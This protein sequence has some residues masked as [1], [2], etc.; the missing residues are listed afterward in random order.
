M[1]WDKP[2]HVAYLREAT[3]Y[4][5][6]GEFEESI[7]VLNEY[8]KINNLV[9]YYLNLSKEEIE[10]F[11]SFDEEIIEL[12]IRT[13]QAIYNNADEHISPISDETF[14]KLYE[15]YREVAGIEIVGSVADTRNRKTSAHKYPE[16]R[17][18]LDKTHF[19]SNSEKKENEKRKSV[20]DWVKSIETKLGRVL[21]SDEMQVLL[22]PKWDGISAVFEQDETH[23]VQKVLKRG[24][25]IKNEAEEITELFKGL[26]LMDYDHIHEPFGLKTEIVMSRENYKK[27]CSAFGEFKSPRSAVS[28]IINSKNPDK[29]MGK[30][31]TIVP[32]R[33][34]YSTTSEIIIP[35]SLFDYPYLTV[36]SIKDIPALEE[37]IRDLTEDVKI[38]YGI[39]ID[40]IVI[41]LLNKSVQAELG[42]E[43]NINKFEVAYKLPPEQERTIIKDVLFSV[44]VLGSVTPVAKVQPVK[45]KGNT[46]SSISLGSIERFK[47]LQLAP[48]DEVILKYDVIPYLEVDESCKRSGEPLFEIP[49]D[50]PYCGQKLEASPELKCVNDD[51]ESRVIGKIMNYVEKMSIPEISIGTITTFWK[52]GFLKTIADLYRLKEH[53]DLIINMDR[54]GH[55]S[56]QNIISGIDSRREVFDYDMVGSIG[57]PSIGRRIFKKILELYTL[58]ELMKI[59]EKNDVAKLT[60]IAGIKDKTA[61]KIIEG[62]IKNKDLIEFLKTELTIIRDTRKYTVK[63]AFTK[64]RDKEFEEYLDSRDVLVLDKYKKDVDMLIVPDY[65]TSSSKVDKARKD[66]KEILSIEDAYKLFK[67]KE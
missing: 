41:T 20:Q 18:T 48:N 1:T 38:L 27:L 30:Y 35:K 25:T 61:S 64:V 3:M 43:H 4:A 58:D 9:N 44:G 24:D 39:D 36:D 12:I 7:K 10:I 37:A 32:L 11:D 14:D 2:K 15:L 29:R 26:K 19:L 13:T 65:S 31:L 52:R 54:F 60:T 53:E 33:L 45:M 6:K 47:T 17:G 42:R 8:V 67:F 23:T 49:K 62:L 63:V 21:A 28:S 57:I 56:Y 55:K 34:Q 50:C 66:G 51:C 59:A 5:L 46:I 16:L 40:G 22:T